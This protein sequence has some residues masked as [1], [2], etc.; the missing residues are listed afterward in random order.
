MSLAQRLYD[1]SCK[2]RDWD[3]HKQDFFFVRTPIGWIA[4]LIH[5]WI[6]DHCDII[7]F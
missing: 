5:D 2:Y 1:W 6:Y 7:P 3:N 4:K